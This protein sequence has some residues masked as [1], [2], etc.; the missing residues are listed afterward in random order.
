[1]CVFQLQ[2]GFHRKNAFFLRLSVL[3]RLNV[4]DD[5]TRTEAKD[6]ELVRLEHYSV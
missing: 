1:M 5:D 6:Y 4:A 3:F 2:I